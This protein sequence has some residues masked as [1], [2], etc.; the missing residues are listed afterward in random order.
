MI[1]QRW[2]ALL[3]SSFVSLIPTVAIAQTNQSQ[4][5][6]VCSFNLNGSDSNSVTVGGDC[7]QTIVNNVYNGSVVYGS[8]PGQPVDKS[9]VASESSSVI[10]PGQNAGNLVIER[11]IARNLSTSEDEGRLQIIRIEPRPLD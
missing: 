11:P 9:S 10:E 3:L 4:T 1:I 6:S 2:N 8:F 7:S 5:H